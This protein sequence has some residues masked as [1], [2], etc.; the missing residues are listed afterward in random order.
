MEQAM[1]T[2]IDALLTQLDH[3]ADDW[4]SPSV[5][6]AAALIRSLLG[7]LQN[8]RNKLKASGRHKL[9]EELAAARAEAEA[10]RQRVTGCPICAGRARIQ[11]LIDDQ[12]S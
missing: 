9:R 3:F 6:N 5:T 2:D 8:C 7:D 10:L 11:Q 4:A 12:T 1:T